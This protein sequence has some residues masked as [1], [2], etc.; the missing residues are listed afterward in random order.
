MAGTWW[1][2]GINPGNW[3]LVFTGS[4]LPPHLRWDTKVFLQTSGFSTSSRPVPWSLN[5]QRIITCLI[6]KPWPVDTGLI[7]AAT[8]YSTTPATGKS[9]PPATD[10]ILRCLLRCQWII[11]LK[12]FLHHLAQSGRSDPCGS[13]P[14]I[15]SYF[16]SLP[17]P[18]ADSQKCCIRAKVLKEL[19]NRHYSL[20]ME[21]QLT[22]ITLPPV[23]EGYA[24]S[25]WCQARC[26]DQSRHFW[27][28]WDS[29]GLTHVQRQVPSISASTHLGKGK[30]SRIWLT[31]ALSLLRTKSCEL[32]W[33]SN[34]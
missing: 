20:E 18:S 32:T 22:Q 21:K 9:T 34:G 30:R 11:E 12:F 29:Y 24:P 6:L 27:A 1:S 19:T 5:K 8:Q 33:W 14:S 17:C 31:Q 23:S 13:Q 2:L 26:A 25:C 10:R 16:L 4:Y 28:H 15:G 7:W 3:T